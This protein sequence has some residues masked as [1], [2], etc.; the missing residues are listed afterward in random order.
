MKKMLLS[1]ML[2]ASTAF[3]AKADDNYYLDMTNGNVAVVLDKV[4]QAPAPSIAE[5]VADGLFYMDT[6][7]GKVVSLSVPK[8]KAKSNCLCDVCTCPDGA[9]PKGCQAK[10]LN[11]G[12]AF[13]IPKGFHAHT[14]A[15]GTVIVHSDENVGDAKAH[16][17]IVHPWKKAARGGETLLVNDNAV[18]VAAPNP[19]AA[20]DPCP[21]GRCPVGVSRTSTTSGQT[22]T[23]SSNTS[24]GRVF[25]VRSGPVRRL[26][27]VL[28][29][30]GRCRSCG[31]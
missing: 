2:V 31:G 9:C 20:A 10:I 3:S 6:A 28:L 25:S 22:F 23:T 26:F 17:G 18:A 14:K 30:G 19:F 12:T 5:A 8:A 15:D 27:G 1:L 16:E 24:A 4:V 21:N 11:P 29:R 7:T 13:P